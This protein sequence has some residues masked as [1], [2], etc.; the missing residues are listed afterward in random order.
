MNKLRREIQEMLRNVPCWR[1][2]ALRRSQREEFLY[3]TDL[4][5]AA[6]TKAVELFL[7][8]A[9]AN[10]WRTETA[11]GWIQ[12]DRE[13]SEPPDGGEPG[14]T[15]PEAHCCASLLRRHP[16]SGRSERERR[17]LIKAGEEG[18]EAYEKVCAQLHREWAE[19]MRKGEPLPDIS[20]RFFE[21]GEQ[22]C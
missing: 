12:L 8:T 2:A 6:D 9:A 18:P 4:P 5:G 3:A 22:T 20:L 15:G 1:P 7:Q 13:C 16:G 11:A 10:G 19:A 17:M 21:G 14:Q